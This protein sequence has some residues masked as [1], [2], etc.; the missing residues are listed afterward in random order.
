MATQT[1]VE[2]PHTVFQAIYQKTDEDEVSFFDI[3][4]EKKIRLFDESEP[5]IKLDDLGITIKAISKEAQDFYDSNALFPLT[6]FY[7]E[8]DEE[9]RNELGLNFSEMKNVSVNELITTSN[10]FQCTD[11]GLENPEYTEENKK[12]QENKPLIIG[13]NVF[14]ETIDD[15]NLN[16]PKS[17]FNDAQFQASKKDPKIRKEFLRMKRNEHEYKGGE[18]PTTNG[19]S[20]IDGF[21]WFSNINKNN[22]TEKQLQFINFYMFSCQY[23]KTT[24]KT[25]DNIKK[26]ESSYFKPDGGITIISH[27]HTEISNDSPLRVYATGTMLIIKMKVTNGTINTRAKTISYNDLNTQN[28]KNQTMFASRTDKQHLLFS[29]FLK[30]IVNLTDDKFTELIRLLDFKPNESRDSDAILEIKEDILNKLSYGNIPYDFFMENINTSNDSVIVQTVL[31]HNY[32]FKVKRGS[33]ENVE[34]INCISYWNEILSRMLYYFNNGTIKSYNVNN[35]FVQNRIK[36]PIKLTGDNNRTISSD[37]NI[38]NILSYSYTETIPPVIF[39]PQEHNRK[40][41]K[42][43][44]YGTITD[45]KNNMLFYDEKTNEVKNEQDKVMKP[46][47]LGNTSNVFSTV[48]SRIIDRRSSIMCYLSDLVYSPNDVVKRVSD[49]MFLDIDSK[50]KIIYIGNYDHDPS[51]PYAF[52]PDGN[53]VPS[54]SRMHVWL[55]INNNFDNSEKTPPALEL[56]IVTRGSKV[57]LDWEDM[58]KSIFQGTALYNERAVSISTV[59]YKILN[60]LDSKY[61]EIIPYM[62]PF[63]KN[64]TPYTRDIQIISSG[65]SLGGFMSLYLSFISLSKNVL[66]YYSSTNKIIQGLGVVHTKKNVHTKKV[67]RI[68]PIWRINSFIIPIVFQPFVKTNTIM[69]IY[70]KIPYGIV[71]TVVNKN[72]DSFFTSSNTLYSDGASADFVSYIENNKGKLS[73]HLYENVYLNELVARLSA[74]YFSYLSKAITMISHCHLLAQMSGLCLYYYSDQI[75]TKLYVKAEL[76]K[77]K[78]SS[79]I[80][81]QIYSWCRVYS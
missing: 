21:K 43:S 8:N 60:D 63:E 27:Y 49:D 47:E 74:R 15:I 3:L 65:H 37:V 18:P 78:G 44:G 9:S 81:N 16:N 42:I 28:G 58:D 68:H 4:K 12:K 67:V 53:V 41:S 25:G 71:N 7:Y 19:L 32:N 56:F 45:Y 5:E 59:I 76:S 79:I 75:K 2:T 62:Q 80:K 17:L 57:G 6:V 64:R 38:G 1:K 46:E 66:K 24:H 35:L 31:N 48:N 77:S 11:L 13:S 50:S 23:E 30:M 10:Y 40:K 70:N 73:L 34:V 22:I 33:G 51:C 36:N 52:D 39:T 69:E 29:I 55:Y 26:I 14:A 61:D 72:K 20:K 54:Y